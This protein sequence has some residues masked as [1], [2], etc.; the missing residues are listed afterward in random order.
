M[1]AKSKNTRTSWTDP[2][3][4][5]ELTDDFFNNATRMIGDKVVSK[6]EFKAAATKIA[7]MGRPPIESPKKAINIRLG[8]DILDAFKATGKGWQT[9]I[10]SALRD[11]LKE[12]KPA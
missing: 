12:H 6:E 3:D 5:P 10:D 2:D 7:K 8:A 11:W 1:N 4:A 9:R